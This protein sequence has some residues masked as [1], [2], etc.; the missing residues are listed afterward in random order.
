MIDPRKGRPSRWSDPL[1]PANMGLSLPRKWS[2]RWGEKHYCQTGVYLRRWRFETPWG[3]VRLHHWL[4]SDDDRAL[5]D[6]PWDFWTYILKGSYTDIS[7][8]WEGFDTRVSQTVQRWHWYYRPARH[9][10]YVEVP[11]TGCWTLVLTGPIVRRWGFWVKGRFRK[12]NK[13]FLEAGQHPC[14]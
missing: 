1:N 11:P 12:A 13:Y 2:V 14:D 8:P 4:K 6:H 10:H 9:R 5:H 3:S 7:S